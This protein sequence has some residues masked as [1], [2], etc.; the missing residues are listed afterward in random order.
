MMQPPMM[1]MKQFIASQDE[2]ITDAEATKRYAEYRVDFRR[3]QINEFFTQH[4]EEEWFRS[5]YHPDEYDRRQDEARGTLKHRCQV[6]MKL[7]ELGR[8]SGVS[9]DIDQTK[10]L[11]R[12]LDAAVILMEGG[13]E[14][15]LKAIDAED[16]AGDVAVAAVCSRGI[17]ESQVTKSLTVDA[18]LD[19]LSDKS[20]DSPDEAEHPKFTEPLRLESDPLPATAKSEAVTPDVVVQET[21]PVKSVDKDSAAAVENAKTHKR[22]KQRHS[23]ADAESL[24]NGSSEASSSEDSEISS[25]DEGSIHS[26]EPDVELKPS[27]ISTDPPTT[28]VFSKDVETA[29]EPKPRPLHR[30]LSIFLRNLSPTI[31]QQEVEA[32]CKQYPGFLRVALQEPQPERRF[33]RRGWVTFQ[34]DVNV[35]E[36]CYNLNQIRLRECDMGAIVNRDLQQRIR[37]VNG[38]TAHQQVAKS[39]VKNAA[40]IIQNFDNRWNMWDDVDDKSDTQRQSFGF[41][42]KN[43][44]MKNI[45]DY[46]V[47]EGSYEEEILLGED[48]DSEQD[49]NGEVTFQRDKDL[50]RVLDRMI[51]YLRIVYSFDY[52]STVEYPHEDAMP[53]RCGIMHVRGP[54]PRGKVTQHDLADWLQSFDVRITPFVNLIVTLDDAEVIKLGKKKDEEE[55]EK[56]IVAN[57]QELAKDKWLCPLS[58]KKFKGPEFV[59][60]HILTKHLDKIDELKKDVIY[61]NTYLADPRRPQLP[62]HP[63]TRMLCNPPPPR[64]ASGYLPPAPAGF[65]GPPPPPPPPP[66]AVMPYRPPPGVMYQGGPVLYNPPPPQFHSR[67]G[68]PD[69]FR[70]G[71]GNDYQP[72]DQTRFAQRRDRTRP[73]PRPVISYTDLDAPPDVD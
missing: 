9:L 22:K 48:V 27:S 1:T 12:V 15:D 60:K 26:D 62:E 19:K 6:F 71:S 65:H 36:I 21:S 13:M 45:T 52:Y 41:V 17:S 30:T 55:I 16:M 47:D 3:Q 61:F 69:R 49:I 59:R 20:V 68:G 72:R 11:V 51:L 58:G 33:S 29:K 24:E 44:I 23:K 53:H 14:F 39:D 32:V 35:K 46:L 10:E 8:L 18:S 7:M 5:K 63:T 70:G 4:K 56:F 57:T 54:V 50:M 66:P 37:P 31:T 73:D 64:E 2:N 43:P 25:S 42:S 28:A 67:G 38:L 40:K 34:G